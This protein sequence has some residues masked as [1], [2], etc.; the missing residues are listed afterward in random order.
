[1]KIT[2]LGRAVIHNKIRNYLWFRDSVY[3]SAP[4]PR[5]VKT[6]LDAVFNSRF[7]A[8][9]RI[10][11]YSVHKVRKCN[12]WWNPLN[13]LCFRLRVLRR[14]N[15][16]CRNTGI[17]LRTQFQSHFIQFIIFIKMKFCQLRLTPRD[18]FVLR[19]VERVY[20]VCHL[21]LILINYVDH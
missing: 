19:L 8:W 3:G 15:K 10:E 2:L 6:A 4:F 12:A 16:P 11:T 17:S 18:C 1:M 13:V 14:R 21:S 5:E 7:S 9:C 20:V